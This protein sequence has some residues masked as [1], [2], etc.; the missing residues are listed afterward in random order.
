MTLY[1]FLVRLAKVHE[2]RA[3]SKREKLKPYFTANIEQDQRASQGHAS[4]QKPKKNK[5]CGFSHYFKQKP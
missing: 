4:R 3:I 5:F 1:R 2:N